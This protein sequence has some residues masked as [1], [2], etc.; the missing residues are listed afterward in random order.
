MGVEILNPIMRIKL[1][2]TIRFK[3]FIDIDW[4]FHITTCMMRVRDE[5]VDVGRLNPEVIDIH[6]MKPKD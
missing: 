1:W 2:C 6:F 5:R 3:V 4:N